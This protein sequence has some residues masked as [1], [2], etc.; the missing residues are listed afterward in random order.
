MSRWSARMG[1]GWRSLRRADWPDWVRRLF[2]ERGAAKSGPDVIHFNN[3]ERRIIV[4][5]VAPNPS[6][7]VEVRPGTGHGPGAAK[8]TGPGSETT[9]AGDDGT[10]PHI[11]KTM[12]DAQRVRAAL[13]KDMSDYRVFAQEWYWENGGYLSRLIPVR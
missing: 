5:D 7:R 1:P 2:P 10:R 4:G 9:R 8:R 6:S 13:P 3:A 12:E 11:E